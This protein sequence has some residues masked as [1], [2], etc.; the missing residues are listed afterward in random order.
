MRDDPGVGMDTPT[1][2]TCHD[3]RPEEERDL[4]PKWAKTARAACGQLDAWVLLWPCPPQPGTRSAWSSGRSNMRQ[5]APV[6]NPWQRPRGSS[7]CRTN[8]CTSRR[9]WTR[10]W[11]RTGW[12]HR[13]GDLGEDVDLTARPVV[14]HRSITTENPS[15]S[16][17]TSPTTPTRQ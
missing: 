16:T 5:S 8:R 4:A 7:S 3:P 1:T 14:P 13:W 11:V 17:S 9:P 6:P 10:R 12:G 15:V 2:P